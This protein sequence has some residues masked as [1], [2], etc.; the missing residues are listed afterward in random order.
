MKLFNA[1]KE[2]SDSANRIVF[3]CQDS[4]G[5][6]VYKPSN[7]FKSTH[8]EDEEAAQPCFDRQVSCSHTHAFYEED[9][10][11]KDGEEYPTPDEDEAKAAAKKA[12]A[13]KAAAKKAVK[14][15]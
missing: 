5:L 1:I 11:Q 13:K 14:K 3:L 10:R 6:Y 9:E 8:Y 2:G 15:K 7:G 12:A 4:N